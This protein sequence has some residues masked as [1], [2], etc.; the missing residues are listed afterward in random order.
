MLPFFSMAVGEA[1]CRTA[2]SDRIANMCTTAKKVHIDEC[3]DII[4]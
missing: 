2:E 4:K 3:E 1:T